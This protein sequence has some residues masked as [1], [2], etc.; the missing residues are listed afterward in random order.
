M[1]SGESKWELI[2][3]ITVVET[4]EGSKSITFSNFGEYSKFRLICNFEVSGSTQCFISLNK[5]YPV[6]YHY[7]NISY[8]RAGNRTFDTVIEVTEDNEFYVHGEYSYLGTAPVEYERKG[9]F[10]TVPPLTTITVWASSA[11]ILAGG[12]FALYGQK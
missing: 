12:K 4:A 11:S 6:I 10:N 2:E 1:Q 3:N 8:N 7:G 5:V 9:N